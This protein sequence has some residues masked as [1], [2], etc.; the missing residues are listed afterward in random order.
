[1][2]TSSALPN[3]CDRYYDLT[4]DAAVRYIGLELQG[5]PGL[6]VARWRYG[7]GAGLHSFLPNAHGMDLIVTV[8]NPGGAS[9]L[10]TDGTDVFIGNSAVVGTAGVTGTG[11]TNQV[12]YWSSSGAISGDTGMTYDPATDILSVVGSVRLGAGSATAPAFSFTADTNTGIYNISGDQLGIATGGTL[13]VTVNTT[14]VTSTLPLL[15]PAGAAATP[16]ITTSGDSDTGLY[17]V[18]ANSL[19]V[20]TNGVLRLTISSTVITPTLPVQN[21]D[22]SAATPS[23]GFSSDTNTG[24][25]WIGADQIG[26]STGGT[27]Q[28]SISTTG[29][30][31]VL[32]VLLPAGSAAAPGV[33]FS[34]DTNTGLYSIGADQLGV[35]I[36]GTLRIT[37]STS[38]VTSTLPLLAPAGLVSAP[39]LSFSGDSDTGLYS[40]GANSLGVAVGGVLQLGITTTGITSALPILNADG[41]V[42]A[43]SFSFS[44]DTNTGIYRIGADQLGFATNGTLALTIST[45]AITAALIGI[46]PAS[47]TAAASIRLP[48]GAAPTSPVNGDMWTT[49]A[50][51]FVR[52]NG[53]TVGP[54]T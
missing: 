24:I 40:V 54:L 34:G 30:T 46:F 41:L 23:V 36:G 27:L 29:I 3:L 48:H 43:P 25:Y 20:T 49:T 52:I 15:A 50:G 44:G 2:S 5:S 37:V 12:A 35:S 18:G 8:S 51:L 9:T 16:S 22:G 33:A 28:M 1:M 11:V 42:T 26:F 53:G 19:G 38:G 31:A 6:D 47:T 21:A 39:S 17:S 4:D 7:T 45:T 13:R 32:P 10:W 14:G